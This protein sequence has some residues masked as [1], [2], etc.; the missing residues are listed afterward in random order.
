MAWSSAS[1]T[2]IGVDWLMV[3]GESLMANARKM[4]KIGATYLLNNLGAA[5]AGL[6]P[7]PSWLGQETGHSKSD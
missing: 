3:V 2:W 4:A 7:C 6:R 5:V 1:N